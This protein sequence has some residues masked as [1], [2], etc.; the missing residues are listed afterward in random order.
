M[1]GVRSLL[2]E[3]HGHCDWNGNIFIK[4]IWRSPYVLKSHGV[5]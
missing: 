2:V 3:L 5:G 1:K 4:E